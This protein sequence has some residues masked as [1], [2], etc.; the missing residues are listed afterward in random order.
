VTFEEVVDKEGCRTQATVFEEVVDRPRRRKNADRI[1]SGD[2]DS[3]SDKT[4]EDRSVEI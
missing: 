3:D 1:V 4:Q 2:S